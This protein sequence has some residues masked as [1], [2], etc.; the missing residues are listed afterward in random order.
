MDTRAQRRA[1]SRGGKEQVAVPAAANGF[2]S[3]ARHDVDFA[4][5]AKAQIAARQ[6]ERG[7]IA[8]AAYY[9][10]MQRGFEPGH[11]LEDWLAAEA[12]IADTLLRPE[13]STASSS[14]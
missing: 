13:A 10:A 11:E 12:E 9:R 2:V 7:K 6:S 14:S 5:M 8:A 1:V 4:A 3:E